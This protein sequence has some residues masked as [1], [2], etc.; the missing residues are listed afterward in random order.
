MSKYDPLYN[1]LTKIPSDVSE[2]TLTFDEIEEIIN[3]KLPPSAYNNRM[4]WGTMPKVEKRSQSKAWLKAG[5]KVA[6]A[7]LP[8][9]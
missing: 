4:W 2:K 6:K 8:E 5:W 7:K 3:D 1:Y 9:K